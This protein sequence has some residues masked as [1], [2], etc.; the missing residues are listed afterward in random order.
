MWSLTSPTNDCSGRYLRHNQ[1]CLGPGFSKGLFLALPDGGFIRVS[2]HLRGAQVVCVHK[3]Q[4]SF[5]LA[6]PRGS[7]FFESVAGSWIP[8]GVIYPTQVKEDDQYPGSAT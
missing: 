1:R 7:D 5:V 2:D 4:F 6:W 8:I 3:V